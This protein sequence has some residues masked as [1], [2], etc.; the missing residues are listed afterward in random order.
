[1]DKLFD[2]LESAN[3]F[4][5]RSKLEAFVHAIAD[6][7]EA[8]DKI[9]GESINMIIDSENDREKITDCMWEIREDFRH[10]KYHIEDA[11]LYD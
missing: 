2:V 8:V 7:K 11:K 10:I 3:Y 6:I 5:S 4:D 1:M 9:Y